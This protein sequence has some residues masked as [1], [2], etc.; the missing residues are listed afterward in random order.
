[1][2]LSK[3]IMTTTERNGQML[4]H[5]GQTY[6]R[7]SS[8]SNKDGSIGWR[9]QHSRGNHGCKASCT[10]KGDIIIRHSKVVHSCQKLDELDIVFHQAKRDMLEYIKK[11]PTTSHPKNVFTAEI[12]KTVKGLDLPDGYDKNI[13]TK[14]PV[15]L[16]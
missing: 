2:S 7:Y 11:A 9:C 6:L 15:S 12:S 3:I 5:D 4:D 10:T 1:M 8:T 16:K 13:A 14:L